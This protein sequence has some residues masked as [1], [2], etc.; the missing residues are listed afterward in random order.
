MKH[1]SNVCVLV[2]CMHVVCLD[3]LNSWINQAGKNCPICRSPFTE[4]YSSDEGGSIKPV[5]KGNTKVNFNPADYPKPKGDSIWESYLQKVWN[6]LPN[7]IWEL[8]NDSGIYDVVIVSYVMSILVKNSK[9]QSE[10]LINNLVGELIP[11]FFTKIFK[12]EPIPTNNDE[13][14]FDLM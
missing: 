1:R 8:L 2:P 9:E 7:R 11:N 5:I 3:C 14:D 6:L 13:I 10:S 4:T 12:V